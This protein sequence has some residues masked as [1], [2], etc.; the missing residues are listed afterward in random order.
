[1]EWPVSSKKN[2]SMFVAGFVTSRLPANRRVF[3]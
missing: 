1:M 2:V 3:V